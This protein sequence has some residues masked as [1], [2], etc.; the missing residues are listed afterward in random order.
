[1]KANRRIIECEP[2]ED[3]IV[4]RM[5]IMNENR[6]RMEEESEQARPKGL[7]HWFLGAR[8]ATRSETLDSGRPA[9]PYLDKVGVFFR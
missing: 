1:M 2:S 3:L 5:R 4:N 8:P 6:M 9:G 7:R